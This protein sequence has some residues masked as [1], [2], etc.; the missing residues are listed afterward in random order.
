M[1]IMAGA[2]K[3]RGLRNV[4]EVL[5]GGGIKVM[6]LCYCPFGRACAEC[7]RREMY[8]MTDE[9]GRAFPLRRNRAA[10]GCRFELYNCAPL[11]AGAG[12]PSAL[13]DCTVGGDGIV[14]YARDPAGKL[15]G[16][17]RGHAA[18]SLL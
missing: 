14:A 15:P 10:A 6:D 13:V 2:A 1:G 12:S 3:G 16:A 8:T 18:R 7:D 11:A 5:C 4:E 9:E 17:T